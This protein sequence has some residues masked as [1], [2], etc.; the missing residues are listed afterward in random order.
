MKKLLAGL[1]SLL[2]S[3]NLAFAVDVNSASQQELETVKGIGPALSSRII[4]E[5]RKGGN[6]KD[7]ADLESRVKGVGENNA[8]KFAE[9]GLTV[10][11]G[12]GSSA[13]SAASSAASSAKG[14]ATAATATPAMAKDAGKSAPTMARDTAKD[15]TDKGKA[16]VSDKAPAATDKAKASAASIVDK[17]KAPK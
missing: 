16:M 5:R 6:F 13:R 9:G 17:S 2:M 11:S 1:A 14:S 4:E 3:M 8:K 7:L 15:A 10:G 12:R